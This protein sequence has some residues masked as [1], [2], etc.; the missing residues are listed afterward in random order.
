MQDLSDSENQ[1]ILESWI[2]YET[3]PL[4]PGRDRDFWAVEKL[5]DITHRDPDR[6]Y[7]LILRLLESPKLDKFVEVLAAGAI[8]DLLTLH[9]PTVIERVEQE[10]R[11]NPDFAFALGGIWQNAMT[12][13]IFTRVQSV[14]NRSGW[15]GNP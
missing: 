10:A 8:E 14:W 6:A 7:S 2:R 11:R 9:G 4:R 13:E 5:K 12:D 3:E 15:D 1:L